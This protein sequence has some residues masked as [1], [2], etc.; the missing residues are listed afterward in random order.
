MTHNCLN[1]F[2]TLPHFT[3]IFCIKN[4][5]CLLLSSDDLILALLVFPSWKCGDNI[6]ELRRLLCE[7]CPGIWG[8]GDRVKSNISKHL[9]ALFASACLYHISYL[10]SSFPPV[11]HND[12]SASPPV[13]WL[14][15]NPI[16]RNSAAVPRGLSSWQP[17]ALCHGNRSWTDGP[18]EG[19][20]KSHL[21]RQTTT[22]TENITTYGDKSVST[23]CLCVS[24]DD[25]ILA[26]PVFPSWECED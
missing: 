19:R 1:H 16:L 7:W 2:I 6:Q 15:S 5:P 21:Q 25:P 12:S 4:Q 10:T 22:Q 18:L 11:S 20:S 17:K 3:Y 26:L 24:S 9:A 23:V 14:I 8:C 13:C